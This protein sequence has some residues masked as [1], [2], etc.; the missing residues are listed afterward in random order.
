MAEEAEE[1]VVA[2]TPLAPA[3]VDSLAANLAALGVTPGMT[4][5]VHSSLRALGWVC[6]GAQAVVLALEQALGPAGTLVMPTHTSDL[7]E[8]SYW[9][10]PPVP[11]AW[12]PIIRAEM[13][14]FDPALTPT[15]GMG[16]IPE[17][18][19]AQ[20]GTRRSPHPHASF[21]ARGPHAAAITGAH[22]LADGLGDGSPLGRIYER[23]GWVLLLGVGHGNN[24]SLHLAEYRAAFPGKAT[25]RQG[26]PITVDGVRQW[27]E[28]DDLDWNDADFVQIGAD[29][30]RDTGLE[31][32]GPVGAATARLLPQRA[33]VDYAA[34]WLPQHRH[35]PSPETPSR[36][37]ET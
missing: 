33:L 23:D 29:F 24:T 2:K 10:H 7:T 34:A 37:T 14:A 13:P 20:P 27:V 3:T 5:L 30:A 17:C 35:A 26:A 16:A 1:A 6:G 15:R 9:Q 19:R 8:P 18:F 11:E 36:L 12:W 4:L 28:F 21:A 25:I 32:Q 22:A 31:R